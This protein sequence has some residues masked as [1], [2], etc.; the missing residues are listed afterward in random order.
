MVVIGNTF[1]LIN[2]SSKMTA[3]LVRILK[4]RFDILEYNTS[5]SISISDIGRLRAYKIFKIFSVFTKL[6]F[7]RKSDTYFIVLNFNIGNSWKL[8]P[9][10]F[11]LLFNK[12]FNSKILIWPH[13]MLEGQNFFIFKL[14]RYFF[15][16]EI[17]CLGIFEETKFKKLGFKTHLVFNFIESDLPLKIKPNDNQ[18]KKML[19]FSNLLKFKGIEDFI[20]IIYRLAN[21]GYEFEVVI[22]GNNA[23]FTSFEIKQKLDLLLKGKLS[24]QIFTNCNGINKFNIIKDCDLLLYPSH[25]DYSPLAVL[26]C[27]FIGLPV[28]SYD[29][30]E[31]KNMII[32]QGAIANSL[33]DFIR[34]TESWFNNTLILSEEDL[35]QYSI[36]QF[37]SSVYEICLNS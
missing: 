8:I 5:I 36:E 6:L 16:S 13:I 30:G 37:Q 19:F 18:F 34:I 24:Y 10:F 22:I 17:I 27:L 25:N 32:K 4:E 21:K 20:E 33:E 26:E 35:S 29:V 31:L 28:I 11:N 9:I 14:F 7:L 2:G 12:R 1:P 3:N 15:K 23:D